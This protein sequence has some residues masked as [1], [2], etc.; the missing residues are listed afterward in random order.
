M[1][2]RAETSESDRRRVIIETLRDRP[3]ATVR[4]LVDV[5]GV[6][7]ATIRR[8][9]GKLHELGAIRKVFGGVASADASAAERVHAKP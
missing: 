7:P 6:S 5:L 1:I 3:F 2:T 8:D 4:D 9:I